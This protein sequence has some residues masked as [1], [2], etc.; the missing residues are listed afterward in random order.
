V[1]AALHLSD[2]RCTQRASRFRKRVSVLAVVLVAAYCILVAFGVSQA[3]G[4]VGDLGPPPAEPEIEQ[5]LTDFYGAGH[6]LGSTVDVR[7]DGPIRVGAP[8][9]HANPPPGPW[10]VRCGYPDQGISPMY[11]VSA[12]VTVTINQG[13]Q[14]SAL[15]PSDSVESTATYN[16]TPCPGV[17]ESLNCPVYYFYRDGQDN[18]QVA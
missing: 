6:P 14:S 5:V 9:D 8:A 10:C 12:L 11:P 4:D 7:F 17:T 2:R 18:W 16:G 15:A 1:R 13:L 3:N